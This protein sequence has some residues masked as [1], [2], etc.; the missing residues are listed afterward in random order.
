M[1]EERGDRTWIAQESRSLEKD[2]KLKRR[3]VEKALRMVVGGGGGTGCR[4]RGK[5]KWSWEVEAEGGSDLSWTGARFL[6][7]GR[8]ACDVLWR[9]GSGRRAAR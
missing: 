4:V 2:A 6:R 5:R 1:Q 3:G 9:A 8:V 7:D